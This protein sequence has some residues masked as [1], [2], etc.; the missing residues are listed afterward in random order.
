VTSWAVKNWF[1]SLLQTL[2]QNA[3]QQVLIRL[4]QIVKNY[5]AE[6]VK[7]QLH[8]A[9]TDSRFVFTL[10]ALLARCLALHVS[11]SLAETSTNLLLLSL[12]SSDC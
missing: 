3:L 12:P 1:V 6:L 10:H 7:G 2:E 8:V 4:S 11:C 9:W 5:V